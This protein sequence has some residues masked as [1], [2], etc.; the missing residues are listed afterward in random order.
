MISFFKS[1]SII[2]PKTSKIFSRFISITQMLGC[3]GTQNREKKEKRFKI[4]RVKI[5]RTINNN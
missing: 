1:G 4:K 2:V 3:K 5:L